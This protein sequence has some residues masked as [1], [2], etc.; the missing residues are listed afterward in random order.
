MT[1]NRTQNTC[2]IN[3]SSLSS[4]VHPLST[5]PTTSPAPWLGPLS[6]SSSKIIARAA[7]FTSVFCAGHGVPCFICIAL[8]TQI[9]KQLFLF[10]C[11]NILTNIVGPQVAEWR[12]S[13][14]GGSATDGGLSPLL[15][16]LPAGSLSSLLLRTS[17]HR[18]RAGRN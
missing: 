4:P 16:P 13:G 11:C 6:L 9:A 10:L 1:M 18:R 5:S 3:G 12:C 2:K 8:F 14:A 7:V 17:S 15:H